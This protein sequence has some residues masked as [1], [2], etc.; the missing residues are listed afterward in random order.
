VV[1]NKLPDLFAGQ[2]VVVFGRFTT[3]PET[4]TAKLKG[5]LGGAPFEMPIKLDLRTGTEHS[6][7]ASMWARQQ[8][9]ALLGYPNSAT[10]RADEALVKKVT[11]LAIQYRVMTEYTSFVAVETRKEKQQDGTLKTVEVPLELPV[12]VENSAYGD[13]GLVGAGY[14]GAGM[15][16]GSIGLVGK[17]G[18]GG[19]GSGYGRGSGAGFGGRGTRVP[20]VRQAKAEV[21][22]S[23]DKEIIR[24]VVRAHI[25]EVRH[26]YNQA[27][28]SDPNAKG[29]VS[30]QFMID[31]SGNIRS[32]VVKE[33]TMIDKAVGVCIS[34]AILRWTFP[35]PTGSS[36]MVTYPFVLEPG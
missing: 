34:K 31:A 3:M 4:G 8:V 20:T 24:R 23:L 19:S 5:R 13:L 18:G 21:Q 22:G 14:G 10:S 9:D 27:L 16:L 35:K 26:C 12:G 36:V 33:D 17:G 6:G 29:R 25:N 1:P 2:P 15:G 28:A 7:L 32:A 11:D 30:V